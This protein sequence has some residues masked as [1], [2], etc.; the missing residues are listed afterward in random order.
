MRWR[1]GTAFEALSKA[2]DAER[3][4]SSG[5]RKESA[6]GR[7]GAGRE[8]KSTNAG[9]NFSPRSSKPNFR[10]PPPIEGEME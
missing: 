5:L 10:T 6:P 9:S 3:P 7:A 1:V 2:G 4:K 8:R